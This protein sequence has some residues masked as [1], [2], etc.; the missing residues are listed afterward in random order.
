MSGRV[1]PLRGLQR[2]GGHFPSGCSGSWAYEPL[3]LERRGLS[4]KGSAPGSVMLIT[5]HINFTLKPLNRAQQ[6]H[7]GTAVPR[8]DRAVHPSSQTRRGSTPVTG[9]WNSTKVV[10]VQ[11]PARPGDSRRDQDA[12]R[13]GAHAVGM[14]TVMEVIQAVHC[15]NGGA[16][17]LRHT[18]NNDRTTTCRP[19]SR[20]SSRT[21]KRRARHS[22]AVPGV[23]ACVLKGP[24]KT[25]CPSA[26]DA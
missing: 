7:P 25:R 6:G 19:P 26:G 3:H 15:G 11:V 18:N 23:L 12:Q 22:G 13:L 24:F 10:T 1:P 17:R 8:H 14:S 16:R 20:P 9:P 5:D 4:P 2:R 21:P